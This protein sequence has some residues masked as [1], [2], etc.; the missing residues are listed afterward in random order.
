MICSYTLATSPA[1]PSSRSGSTGAIGVITLTGDIAAG[2]SQLNVR[3]VPTGAARLR[4]W[5]DVDSIVVAVISPTSALLFPHGGAAITRRA[6]AALSAAGFIRAIDSTPV[7]QFPEV[8]TLIEARMLAALQRAESP[9][10]IDLLL[11]QPRR[12]ALA[13]RD[14]SLVLTPRD[15]ARLSALIHPPTVVALGPPNIGKSSMLNALAGRGV[16]IVADVP[17]TTRDHVGVSLNLAGLVVRYIDTPGIGRL[18]PTDRPEQDGLDAEAQQIAH[19][20]AAAADLLLLCADPTS[21]FLTRPTPAANV[22]CVALRADLGPPPVGADLRVSV[23]DNS[24]LDVLV[25]A[26]KD[27]LIP[28]AL[29][30]DPRAWRF[31]PMNPPSPPYEP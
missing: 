4:D 11:D 9:L 26:I 15:S 19:R 1:S 29:L 30:A 20:V 23:R 28:P 24:G 14:A 22:L 27:R 16:S 8:R 12:W 18:A 13:E 6:L 5:P 10:A 17:G 7:E 2:L 21:A 31:W 3:P 25:A